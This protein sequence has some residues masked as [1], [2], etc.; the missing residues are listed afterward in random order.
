MILA[1][2]VLQGQLE[3]EEE[4]AGV[5][6]RNHPALSC[7]SVLFLMASVYLEP[8]IMLTPGLNP[9]LHPSLLAVPLCG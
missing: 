9:L 5:S 2:S 3:K 6:Q 1:L 7:Y 4:V 8:T